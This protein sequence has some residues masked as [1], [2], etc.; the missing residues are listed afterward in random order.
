MKSGENPRPKVCLGKLR[1][2]VAGIFR[3][4]EAATARQDHHRVMD[5][6]IN[7]RHAF[8]RPFRPF[9]PKVEGTA[10]EF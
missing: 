3:G 4:D 1:D 7:H 8:D 5:R 9:P 2:V 10:R 6:G